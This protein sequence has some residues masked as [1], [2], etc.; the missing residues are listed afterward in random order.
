MRIFL[1][2]YSNILFIIKSIL[3]IIVLFNALKLIWEI[4]G[5]IKVKRSNIERIAILKRGGLIAEDL[6]ELT[7]KE[8][9]EWCK[10]FLYAEGFINFQDS[11]SSNAF[12]I[13]FVCSRGLDAYLV[14]CK[15]YD[16]SSK[17]RLNS[18]ICK[19]LLGVMEA[20]S[21]SKGIIITSGKLSN[22]AVKFI[23]TMPNNYEILVFDQE[24]LLY[25]YRLGNENLILKLIRNMQK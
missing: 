12:N 6:N 2:V 17:H 19:E 10:E 16:Q 18:D 5:Q 9:R 25:K 13:D 7:P 11:K 24:R 1:L 20:N 3:L 14:K 8:F 15:I 4:A 21:V 23:T 22:E